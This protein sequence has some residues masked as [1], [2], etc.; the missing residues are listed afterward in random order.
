MGGELYL[1]GNGRLGAM[2]YGNVHEEIIQLNEDSMYSGKYQ[3]ADNPEF[4]E[5]LMDVRALL[6]AG[7]YEK[8]HEVAEKSSFVKGEALIIVQQPTAIMVP[9]KPW[10]IL[11]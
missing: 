10:V 5:G 2:V 8:A 7:N 11:F 6:A 9:T 3:D 4:F 1:I